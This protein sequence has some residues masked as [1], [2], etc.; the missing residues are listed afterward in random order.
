MAKT[1]GRNRNNTRTKSV[2]NGILLAVLLVF[3]IA[4][5]GSTYSRYVSTGTAETTGEIAKWNVKIGNTNLSE[6]EN[7][8]L[9]ARSVAGISNENVSENKLAPGQTLVTDSLVVNP[10]GSEVAIDYI[11]SVG[12]VETQG[13][14]T[15]S[16]IEATKIM[17]T[18]DGAEAVEVGLVDGK[19][20]FY[21]TLEDVLAGKKATFVA[22]ISWTD[23]GNNTADTENGAGVVTSVQV[24]VEITA[25]QHLESD[26]FV[27]YQDTD[28]TLMAMAAETNSYDK[29][30][31][32]EDITY[33]DYEQYPTSSGFKVGFAD[34]AVF[35]LAG[36]TVTAPNGALHYAGDN[37]TIEN[38]NFVGLISSASGRYGMHLWND[39]ATPDVSTGVVIQNVTTTGINLYNT[40]VT[41]RNVTITMPDDA[42]FYTIYGNVYSTITIESGTYTAGNNTTALFGY[43]GYDKTEV[44]LATDDGRNPQDGFKIYG[45]TFNTNGKP[46]CLTSGS[47]IP[48]V[49][50]GGTFD[51]DVS[52]YVADGHTCTSQGNGTWVVQ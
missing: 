15:N 46:F 44:G 23:E 8:E 52:S 19:Y 45:G 40:E 9:T 10:A 21:E 27:T 41:L 32:T 6:V 4:I 20:T 3:I 34:N 30:V 28:K 17:A 24:P 1:R 13:F 42:K 25:R 31:L 18:L 33:D 35:D 2:K 51:C 12:E 37:L 11:L 26:G 7:F 14:N 5:I 38:G 36:K 47:H 48:P 16:T 50:Y 29:L 39:S 22:H 43:L 49:I